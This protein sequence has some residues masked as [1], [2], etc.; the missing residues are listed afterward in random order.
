M[1]RAREGH[2][3]GPQVVWFGGCSE[4]LMRDII[5]DIVAISSI[6]RMNT[7]KCL[8]EQTSHIHD[9]ISPW[10]YQLEFCLAQKLPGFC[11]YL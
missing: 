3:L 9:I 5:R 10:D 2:E 8:T 6:Q 11:K 1:L 4:N 7:I